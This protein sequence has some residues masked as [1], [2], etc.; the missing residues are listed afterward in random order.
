[1]IRERASEV[2]S[3]RRRRGTGSAETVRIDILYWVCGACE[4]GRGG[5]HGA[6]SD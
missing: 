6:H 4:L 5:V 3:R 1:V 2:R